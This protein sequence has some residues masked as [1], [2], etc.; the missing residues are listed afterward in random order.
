MKG[1]DLPAKFI[2]ITSNKSGGGGG[3][4]LFLNAGRKTLGKRINGRII[5]TREEGGKI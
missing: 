3:T 2:L 4:D 5:N 1:G